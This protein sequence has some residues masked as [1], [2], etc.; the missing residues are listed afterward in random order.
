MKMAIPQ[1]LPIHEW[2]LDYVRLLPTSELEWLDFKQSAW[3][4]PD[5]QTFLKL[6]TYVSAFANYSGGYLVIGCK[7]PQ[8]GV[9]L[10][11]DEGVDFSIKNGIQDWLED[12][13]PPLVDPPVSGIGIQAIPFT[14]GGN[15]GIVVIRIEPSPD[16][17]HQARDKIFYQRVA[18]KNKGLG[19]QHVMDIRNRKRH[20]E[21]NVTLRL[22]VFEHEDSDDVRGNLMWEIENIS[23]IF[24][25][26]VAIVIKAPLSLKGRA[27][28]YE[29]SYV[30]NEEGDPGI[31]FFRLSAGNGL[32]PL[33][34][35]G[36]LMGR[37]TV[38]LM[39]GQW[40]PQR[41]TS[42]SFLV[43]AYADGCPAKEFIIPQE[44]VATVLFHPRH[45]L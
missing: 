15:V 39:S 33:F 18:S 2:T 32:Q 29:D 30:E 17:P 24:C 40:K 1:L 27:L 12:K 42:D 37:F 13:I 4:K 6:S 35:R 3:L 9:P 11:L 26:H 23:D 16:A 8:S 34:P 41:Q 20:P 19:T 36:K 14:P 45:S 5:E 43:R 10:E 21:V 31:S 25:R 22:T 38:R 44:E 7:N 28:A